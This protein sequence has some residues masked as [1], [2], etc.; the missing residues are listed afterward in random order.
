MAMQAY[1]ALQLKSNLKNALKHVVHHNVMV[2]Q[3]ITYNLMV[4]NL[5][6]GLK[7]LNLI[8]GYKK[9]RKI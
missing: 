4:Y 9:L 7:W 6:N 8:F 1:S 2:V 5:E 3:T